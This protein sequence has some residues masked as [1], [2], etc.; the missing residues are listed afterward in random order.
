MVQLVL[1]QLDTW[2]GEPTQG[3]DRPKLLSKLA[4]LE[5]CGWLEGEL[6]RLV[7]VAQTGRLDD[8]AW[9]KAN[10]LD[11]T[12]GFTYTDHFR[13]MLSKVVGELFV[14]RI[15][16]R[17][18]SQH[19]GELERLKAMLGVLWKQRCGFAHADVAAN[20]AA[21]QTFSAPSWSIN[22]YRIISRLI[23]QYEQSMLH[24]L[25]QL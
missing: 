9:V 6:D 3:G 21:Q 12:N 20:V 8:P 23:V 22:Q 13:P 19:Q 7:N 11:R 4:V 10:V 2:Y 16:L 1:R 17:M 24:V 15:E 14:R 18:E 25:G 5:L